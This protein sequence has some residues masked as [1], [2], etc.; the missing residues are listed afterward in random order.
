MSDE[1]RLVRP[2]D[3][4]EGH[5]TPGM[6]REEAVATG[7]MWAGHV[8]TGAGVASGWHHHGEYESTIY[9]VSGALRMEFGPGGADVLEATAGDF[10]YVPPHAV[11]RELNPAEVE[12]TLVVVRAGSGEAVVNVDGPA[13]A[14][15]G[16]AGPAAG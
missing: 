12:S 11:H 6:H 10:L 16:G 2:E 7:G 3:R 4:S 1:V 14:A 5:P 9:V 13:P 15:D 8:T